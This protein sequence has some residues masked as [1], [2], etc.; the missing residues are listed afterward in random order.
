MKKKIG[1]VMLEKIGKVIFLLKEAEDWLHI[2]EIARKTE[3]HPQTVSNIIDKYLNNFVL[4]ENFNE[5]GLKV[6]LIKLKDKNI[7]LERLIRYL[8]VI[9]KIE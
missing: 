6:K 2:R 7:D 3:I 4:V 5:Y 9:S 8:N 1:K